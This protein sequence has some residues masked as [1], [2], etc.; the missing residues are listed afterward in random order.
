M[1]SM[2]CE[3]QF[4]LD[5]QLE[6]QKQDTNKSSVYDLQATLSLKPV[7]LNHQKGW[8]AIKADNVKTNGTYAG[9]YIQ[10]PFAFKL[11]NQGLIAEYWYPKLLSREEED[12]LSRLSTYYQFLRTP[13]ENQIVQEMESGLSFTYIYNTDVDS[14]VLYKSKRNLGHNAL[15][16]YVKSMNVRQ[17]SIA[18]QPD[19]CFF[20][21]QIGQEVIDT[22]SEIEQLSFLASHY[23][24]LTKQKQITTSSLFSLPDELTEWDIIQDVTLS[25]AELEEQSKKLSRWVTQSDIDSLKVHQLSKELEAYKYALHTLTNTFLEDSLS[26]SKNM[27]LLVAIGLIDSKQSNA[28]LLSITA[29]VEMPDST[30]FRALHALKYGDNRLSPDATDLIRNLV[31][32]GVETD[33]EIMQGSLMPVIGLVIA[34]RPDDD[35][36]RSLIMSLENKLI[37]EDNPVKKGR[38]LV[39]MGNTKDAE[40]LYTI[41]SYTNDESS[42]VRGN[43]AY[44]LGQLG[45]PDAYEQL[46]TMLKRESNNDVRKEVFRA[47]KKHEINSDD[48]QLVTTLIATSSDPI[49][50]KEGI[51]VLSTQRKSIRV[52]ELKKLLNTEKDRDNLRSIINSIH[53]E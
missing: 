26:E 14:N 11:G 23:Y 2:A 40:L 24:V 49:F 5:S 30:R 18:I 51:A 46:S 1:L 10:L 31:E 44:A 52:P 47:F 7:T 9:K 35:N 6:M 4:L 15:P 48:I 22:R 19:N 33:S 3:T 39:S 21:K 45:T 41:Q 8:W 42:Y 50:R 27:K 25:D 37:S 38:L 29:N 12:S 34:D 28:L 20:T 16:R 36:R 17:S 43:A 53:S 13:K 32:N